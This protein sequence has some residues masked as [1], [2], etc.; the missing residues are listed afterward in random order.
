[1]MFD[2]HPLHPSRPSPSQK[3][4]RENRIKNACFSN[5]HSNIALPNNKRPLFVQIPA[6][7]SASLVSTSLPI[8]CIRQSN[9]FFF[10]GIF[11]D[12]FLRNLL[13]PPPQRIP[14][15]SERIKTTSPT[16]SNHL[17]TYS[18]TFG[19]CRGDRALSPKNRRATRSLDLIERLFL[20]VSSIGMVG[21][22]L[23]AAA[24]SRSRSLFRRI[25]FSLLWPAIRWRQT[26]LCLF[27]ALFPS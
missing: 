19:T 7:S 22:G 24:R 16:Y 18:D 2:V 9:F 8:K 3:L 23:I 25:L 10:R 26:V 20:F 17:G 12:N 1:M 11:A 21:G 15:T 6:T 27:S 4:N 13:E 14:T 5:S